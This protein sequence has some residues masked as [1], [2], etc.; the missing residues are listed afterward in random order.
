[1]EDFQY[2]AEDDE[3]EGEDEINQVTSEE[4]KNIL[5]GA[6]KKTSPK[7]EKKPAEVEGFKKGGDLDKSLK[8]AKKNAVSNI[9][10]VAED[11]SDDEDDSEAAFLGEDDDESGEDFGQLD[12][13]A[14]EGE[15]EELDSD[16]EQDSD[17]DMKK[18]DAIKK[19]LANNKGEQK[20]AGKP[21][22]PTIPE[23]SDPEDDDESSDEEEQSLQSML[24]KQHKK[25]NMKQPSPGKV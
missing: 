1:M 9:V 2:D 25:P 12:L 13:E 14:E 20:S 4:L 18:V 24:K 17:E 19:K 11:S 21:A 5:N 23:L 15:D 8:A 10:Q 22:T 16:L 3:E 6:A 7:G